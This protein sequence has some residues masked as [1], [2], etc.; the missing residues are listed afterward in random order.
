MSSLL[1]STYGK[2]LAF[3]KLIIYFITELFHVFIKNGVFQKLG[4]LKLFQN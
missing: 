4:P 1:M 2:I 3:I